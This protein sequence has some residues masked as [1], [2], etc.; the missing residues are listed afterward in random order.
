MLYVISL[1]SG[2]LF[3]LG[4]VLSGMIN[5]AKVLGF[6]D[7]F[8]DWDPSLGL[9]MAGALAVYA[10]GFWLWRKQHSQCVLGT[11]LPRVPA[12]MIDARL[13][14]GALIFGIGWGLVGICPG[15]AIGLTG[16]LQW[17]AGLF[18]LAMAAGFWL[19]GRLTV[20]G[21]GKR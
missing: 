5:P 3:G 17:Q 19:V 2:G 7:L 20:A 8:G 14:L 13:L 6:L 21:S 15:P 16:S 12:P 11:D 18:V 10:T 4:L 1:L 9:V